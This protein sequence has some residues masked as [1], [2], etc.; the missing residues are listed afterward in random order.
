MKASFAP[1]SDIRS[2]APLWRYVP[3]AVDVL[4]WEPNGASRTGE[5]PPSA[6]WTASVLTLGLVAMVI[7]WVL[8]P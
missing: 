1:Y 3:D 7:R 4:T 6:I 8:A 5:A 2:S